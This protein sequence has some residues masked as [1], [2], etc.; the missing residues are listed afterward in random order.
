MAPQSLA[1]ETKAKS[2]YKQFDKAGTENDYT[3]VFI[4]TD[5]D[6]GREMSIKLTGLYDLTVDDFIL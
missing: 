4:D 5:G 2:T 1:Q 6:T 3:M